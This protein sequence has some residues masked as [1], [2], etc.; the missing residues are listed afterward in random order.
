MLCNAFSWKWPRRSR[1]LSGGH[2]FVTA[3][4][5]SADGERPGAGGALADQGDA[6]GA[7]LEG[8]RWNG[9]EG[10]ALAGAGEKIAPQ[11]LEVGH[12]HGLARLVALA[13]PLV[14]VGAGQLALVV[15]QGVGEADRV[16]DTRG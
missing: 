16:V 15:G 9:E 14:E 3:P 6:V 4:G 10:V 5:R 13:R 2:A 7:G 11:A 8:A 1:D 12:H